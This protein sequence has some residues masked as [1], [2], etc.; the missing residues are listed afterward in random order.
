MCYF[1]QN[2]TVP[3]EYYLQYPVNTTYNKLTYT[4][5]LGVGGGVKGNII[6]RYAYITQI[7]PLINFE[8]PE[9]IKASRKSCSI[10][11]CQVVRSKLESENHFINCGM[12]YIE[13]PSS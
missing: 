8:K 5:E 7:R 2:T 1:L 9:N 4:W 11:N 6:Q 10:T 13:L 12:Q 3:W